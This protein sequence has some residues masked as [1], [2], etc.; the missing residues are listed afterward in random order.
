[1]IYLIVKRNSTIYVKHK[2]MY[3]AK[4]QKKNGKKKRKWKCNSYMQ[5]KTHTQLFL[6]LYRKDEEKNNIT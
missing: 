1:M 5:N 2:Y 4:K 6:K 3:E